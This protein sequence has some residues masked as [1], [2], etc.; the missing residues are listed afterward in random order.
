MFPPASSP[1]GPWSA[2]A[3]GAGGGTGRRATR[4]CSSGDR[5]V[6]RMRKKD[7]IFLKKTYD[8]C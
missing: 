3:A 8:F 7:F 2:A 4:T 1:A 6:V 5:Y